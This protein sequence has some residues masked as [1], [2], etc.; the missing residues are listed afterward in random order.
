M[1]LNSFLFFSSVC[2]I[3]SWFISPT[4][5]A[6]FDNRIEFRYEQLFSSTFPAKVLASKQNK[7]TTRRDK[8]NAA[9]SGDT[10][11]RKSFRHLVRAAFQ[12][13]FPNKVGRKKNFLESLIRIAVLFDKN[14]ISARFV[15]TDRVPFTKITT[16]KMVTQTVLGPFWN[17]SIIRNKLWKVRMVIRFFKICWLHEHAT[18][19]SFMSRRVTYSLPENSYLTYGAVTHNLLEQNEVLGIKFSQIRHSH[20]YLRKKRIIAANWE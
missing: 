4:I 9:T 5:F 19:K 13:Y 2:H 6:H 20:F 12:Q 10:R 16:T 1:V 18:N 17:Y 14:G 8:N 11:F 3:F 15:L 7:L